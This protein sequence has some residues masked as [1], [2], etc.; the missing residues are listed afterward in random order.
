MP[1]PTNLEL[2]TPWHLLSDRRAKI[3]SAEL[4]SEIRPLHPLHGLS[5]KAVAARTDRDD[6][7]FEVA[8]GDAPL[9]VVHLTWRKETDPRWPS[10]KFFG[11]W[12]HWV[13]DEML[14]DHEGF[15]L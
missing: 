2:L 7:L 13:H 4:A 8:G 12:D 15:E 10:V 14:L 9:A 11:S 5:A 3:L 1:V 6:V